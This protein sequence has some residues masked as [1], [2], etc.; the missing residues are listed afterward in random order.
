[1]GI[2][3]LVLLDTCLPDY[4]GGYHKPV[5]Q[6][7]VWQDMTKDELMDAIVS[8]YNMLWDYLVEKPHGTWPDLKDWQVHSLADN[9]I[10]ENMPFENDDIPTC[11]ECEETVDDVCIFIICEEDE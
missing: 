10:I 5:M 11:D 1:M 8:D 4:F 6:I 9:F 7:P 3:K 2:H